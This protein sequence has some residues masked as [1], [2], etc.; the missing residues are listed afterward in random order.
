[1]ASANVLKCL[2]CAR[3]LRLINNSEENDDQ[4]DSSEN[5]I[6]AIS[7]CQY[8]EQ[9]YCCIPCRS[10][11]ATCNKCYFYTPTEMSDS[12]ERYKVL[13]TVAEHR[14]SLRQTLSVWIIV[15]PLADL[16]IDYVTN[17]FCQ[18]LSFPYSP[19][20]D[21]TAPPDVLTLWKKHRVP[22]DIELVGAIMFNMETRE[23]SRFYGRV[24]VSSLHW[25]RFDT[26]YCAPTGES[27]GERHSWRCNDCG[28]EF[29]CTDK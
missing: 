8:D 21:T 7:S 5:P 29:S 6:W 19:M 4:L 28:N 24:D 9:F 22:D 14:A 23:P 3:P 27:G 15:G 13:P 16:I 26:T 11:Y 12:V 18:L 10:F 1:M 25:Y 17:G 2:N 20:D